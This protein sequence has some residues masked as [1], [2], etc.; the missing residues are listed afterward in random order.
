MKQHNRLIVFSLTASIA[1]TLA[2]YFD[3]SLFSYQLGENRFDFF[4]TGISSAPSI[5]W[6]GWLTLAVL[7]GIV[8][9]AVLP[10]KLASRLSPDIVW[11]IPIVLILTAVM[12]EMRWFI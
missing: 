4:A 8:V 12:Y 9:A 5:L 7:T 10:Q 11:L 3:W 6:Y 1:Y 2:Y